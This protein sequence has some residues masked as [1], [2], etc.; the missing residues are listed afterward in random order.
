MVTKNVEEPAASFFVTV[1]QIIW[2][3]ILEEQLT[4]RRR[5]LPENL[6]FP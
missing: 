3:H 2:C 4:P 5:A 6:T 1:Y